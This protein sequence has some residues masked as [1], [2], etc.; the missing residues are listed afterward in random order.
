MK[1]AHPACLATLG[2]LVALVALSVGSVPVSDAQQ[3]QVR[4]K[5]PYKIGWVGVGM[6]RPT[7]AEAQPSGL[8]EGKGL[9]VRNVTSGSPAEKAGL[10]PGDFLLRRGTEELTDAR[11]FLDWAKDNPGAAAD[12]VIWR[13]HEERKL[14]LLIGVLQLSS[15]IEKMLGSALHWLVAEQRTDGGWPKVHASVL[16]EEAA[17]AP[18]TTAIAAVALLSAPPSLRDKYA[19]QIERGIE[20]LL[21][22]QGPDGAIGMPGEA[23]QLKSF[24]TSVALKACCLRDPGRYQAEIAQMVKFF[25][26]N[27]VEERHGFSPLDWR[28]GGWNFFDNLDPKSGDRV[29]VDLCVARFVTD[30]LQLA[31][32]PAEHPLWEKSR[33]HVR[34]CQNWQDDEE[35]LT[36]ADDGGFISP[37]RFSKAGPL[38]LSVE[39]IRFRSYGSTTCDGLQALL[40]L[41]FPKDHPRVQSAFQWI[42]RNYTIAQN[43]GFPPDSMFPF[44][45]GLYYYYLMTLAESLRAYGQ[46]RILTP[47]GTQHY[48]IR[49]IT[50][51]LSY[52][53]KPEGFWKNRE[54]VM[55]EDDP[56]LATSL[57]AIALGECWSALQGRE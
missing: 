37:P 3:E 34:R 31:G 7:K 47:D 36:I 42:C 39:R 53:Q 16:G 52:V 48:W 51:Q 14:T 8:P 18:P 55:S 56:I 20:Y 25:E 10:Q 29:R 45:T 24:V 19:R 57:S 9:L 23:W 41:G 22:H 5:A 54:N 50:Y 35:R 6:G 44:A 49:E 13:D 38:Y 21:A 11:I 30:A 46:E 32:V 40:N 43:P 1:S 17:T 28:Y 33:I 26:Q 2:A 15:M 4:S 12:L 27:Q